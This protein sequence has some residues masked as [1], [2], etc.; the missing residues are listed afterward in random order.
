MWTHLDT[1]VVKSTLGAYGTREW[2]H[3]E[4][5]AQSEVLGGSQWPGFLIS[6]ITLIKYTRDD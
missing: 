3:W 4:L 1:S 6:S 2:D 5:W